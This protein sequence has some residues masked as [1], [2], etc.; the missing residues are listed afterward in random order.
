MELLL[1]LTSVDVPGVDVLENVIVLLLVSG[2]ISTLFP[3]FNSTATLEP[4]VTS[5]PFTFTLTVWLS[6]CGI[7]K[8]TLPLA[9]G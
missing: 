7:V 2:T 4:N 1:I 6:P 3:A 5:L 9:S 8:V